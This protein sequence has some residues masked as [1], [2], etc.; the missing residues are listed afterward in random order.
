MGALTVISTLTVKLR[1]RLI[2]G[3]AKCERKLG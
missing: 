2:K 3:L 1:L